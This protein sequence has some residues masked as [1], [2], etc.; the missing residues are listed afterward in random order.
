[1]LTK[2]QCCPTSD[3]AGA[4]ILCSKDFVL[5]HKLEN[6]AVEICGMVMTTDDATTFDDKFRSSMNLAG[7]Q[8][9]L[10]IKNFRL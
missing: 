1:M 9:F 7:K 5:K 4:V 8:K 6:Q 2:L 3:G 10:F